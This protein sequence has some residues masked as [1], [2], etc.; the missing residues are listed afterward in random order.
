MYRIKEQIPMH[1]LRLLLVEF[2]WNIKYGRIL[3][4]KVLPN[5]Q[6]GKFWLDFLGFGKD[7]SIT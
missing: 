3:R 2:P 7:K 4:S 6:S 1:F 5:A